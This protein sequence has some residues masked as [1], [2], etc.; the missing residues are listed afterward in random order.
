MLEEFLSTF[1]SSH[2]SKHEDIKTLHEIIS[3]QAP[4]LEAELQGKSTL[5]YGGFDYQT[6]SKCSGRWARIGIMLNK[7][8]LSLMISGEKDGKYLLE[9]YPKNHFGKASVGKSCVRFQ[10]LDDLKLDHIEELVKAAAD[11]DVSSIE[12]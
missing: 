7:T 8:G 2:E 9:G 12:V 5:A 4:S 3:H 11:A 1:A 6:K 10:K